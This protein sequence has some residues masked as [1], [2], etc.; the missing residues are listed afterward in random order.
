MKPIGKVRKTATLEGKNWILELQRFLLNNRSTPHARPQ[1]KSLHASYC[2]IGR[3]KE[4]YRNST[5]KEVIDKRKEA[6]KNIGK[7]KTSIKSI[8]TSR[9]TVICEQKPVNKLSPR[10]NPQKFTVIKRKGATVVAR[11]D[12]RT[13]TRNVF[14]FK[15]VKFVCRY[16]FHLF[17]V[18]HF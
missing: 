2:S 7:R 5:T 15:L 6:K 17:H 11:N 18:F 16:V 12:R 4:L 8:M 3:Y 13:I 9:D 14:H 10:F 1:R